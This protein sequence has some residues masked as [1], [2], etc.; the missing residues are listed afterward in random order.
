[1]VKNV[2]NAFAQI[3]NDILCQLFEQRIFKSQNET[4]STGLFKHL[5]ISRKDISMSQETYFQRNHVL[6]TKRIL[7]CLFVNNK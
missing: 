6:D 3:L 7:I 2:Q 1:M 5:N 4:K